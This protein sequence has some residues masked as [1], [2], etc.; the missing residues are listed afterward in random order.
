MFNGCCPKIGYQEIHKVDFVFLCLVVFHGSKFSP[1][2]GP[3]QSDWSSSSHHRGS[4]R[5][6]MFALII[7]DGHG[8]IWGWSQSRYNIPRL[9]LWL[10]IYGSKAMQLVDF[11]RIMNTHHSFFVVFY[12][13]ANCGKSNGK[14]HGK[15]MVTWR[16]N[17]SRPVARCVRETCIQFAPAFPSIVEIQGFPAGRPCGLPSPR[18]EFD[19]VG[20]GPL[21]L[22]KWFVISWKIP[23]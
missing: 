8:S 17:N 16:P 21:L 7:Y 12:G 3:G 5:K 1:N 4:D 14:S 9:W 20:P 10:W 23:I 19:Q 13:H 6:L 18:R 11:C 15:S 2:V 22:P